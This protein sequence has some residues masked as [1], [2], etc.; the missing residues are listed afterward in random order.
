MAWDFL[1]QG[2]L[3]GAMVEVLRGYHI[4]KTAQDR[5]GNTYGMNRFARFVAAV[6]QEV[7]AAFDE[8]EIDLKQLEE[9]APGHPA[10]QYS[11]ER[12]QRL[13]GAGGV[14]ERGLAQ[15]VV[16]HEVGRMPHKIPTEIRYQTKRSLGRV[17]LPAFGRPAPTRPGLEVRL[18]GQSLGQ[19]VVL[20]DILLVARQNLDDR[21]A[22]LVAKGIGRAA[23]KTILVDR[24]AK[25]VEE[26]HGEGWGF[27][28]GVLGSVLQM[29]TERADLRSWVTLPQ[30]I[31]VLRAPVTTGRHAISV[32]LPGAGEIDLGM[33]SFE[34]GKPVLVTVRSMGG[35]VYA[36]VGPLAV[37]AAT[38]ATAA[39]ATET[40]Q[41]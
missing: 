3:D 37:P 16:V 36:Q 12:V 2:N 8:A 24:A 6:A 31:E 4:Q 18:A 27:L 17:S 29:S 19:T 22:W 23:A 9:E 11:L 32:Q 10:V 39:P 26:K 13:Q 38:P 40:S 7:D 5:Y 28:A 1:R 14:E 15:L 25:E 41:P 30:T 21:L 34:V 20:E 35:R 33:H